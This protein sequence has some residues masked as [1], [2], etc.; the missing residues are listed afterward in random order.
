M[1][2][3]ALPVSVSLTTG[4]WRKAY[5][6][7]RACFVA[8]GHKPNTELFEG[9]LDINEAGYLKTECGTMKTNYPGCLRAAMHRIPSYRQAVTAA[10]TGCMAAI[11]AERFFAETE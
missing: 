9:V 2:P 3:K 1:P 11:V 5:F 10:G 7:R 8:I 6:R 4:Q